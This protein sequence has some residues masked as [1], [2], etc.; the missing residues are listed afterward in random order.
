MTSGIPF[1]KPTAPKWRR[2]NLRQ[3]AD[4]PLVHSGDRGYLR[5]SGAGWESSS[6]RQAGCPGAGRKTRGG[7]KVKSGSKMVADRKDDQTWTRKYLIFGAP[8]A[9]GQRKHHNRGNRKPSHSNRRRDAFGWH[10]WLPSRRFG[11]LLDTLA[12]NGFRF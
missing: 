7:G 11:H 6:G 3:R 5:A 2:L 1:R 8:G 12:R 10:E 9:I 4:G